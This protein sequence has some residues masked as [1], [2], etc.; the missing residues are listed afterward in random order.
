[1]LR[2]AQFGLPFQ[3]FPRA[4][5]FRSQRGFIGQCLEIFI[6]E[7]SFN[8]VLL[9]VLQHPATHSPTLDSNGP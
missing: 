4:C 8:P 9:R 2:L 5:N 1:M 6:I 3:E 7:H